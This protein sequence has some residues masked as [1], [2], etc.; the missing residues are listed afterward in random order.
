MTDTSAQ[1]TALNRI[2]I[3][4]T[5]HPVSSIGTVQVCTIVVTD[6]KNV[7]AQW[8]QGTGMKYRNIVKTKCNVRLGNG[9]HQQV[10]IKSSYSIDS[11]PFMELVEVNPAVG[12]WAPQNGVGGAPGYQGFAVQNVKRAH[13][14]MS[15][16]G[17][18]R[19]AHYENDFAIYRGQNGLLVKL[20]KDTLLPPIGEPNI[21]TAPIVFG[22]ISHVD[23]AILKYSKVKEQ[24][25]KIL[26]V[27]PNQ[28]YTEYFATDAL[29]DFSGVLVETDVQVAVSNTIP[30]IQFENV[31]PSLGV[32]ACTKKTYNIHPA[33]T[34]PAFT[35]PDIN[36]QM[37]AAG[38]VLDTKV[39]LPEFGGLILAYYT[40]PGD[41]WI[42]IVDVRFDF[43]PVIPPQPE[44]Q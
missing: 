23:V 19:I 17:F 8:E 34:V 6:L 2:T 25:E 14:F 42:E 28:T 29:M 1:P 5:L 26:G 21:P 18:D 36:L 31:L 38:F 15:E 24:F 30:T 7:I 27:L 13:R 11:S 39:D 12:P 41:Y 16:A 9:S 4:S 43:T 40:G 33:W 35:L 22:K 44:S 3:G 10:T 20:I 37:L 32:F